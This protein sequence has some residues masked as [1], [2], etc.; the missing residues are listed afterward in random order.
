MKNKNFLIFIPT[1]NEK[2][3]VKLIYNELNSLDLKFDILFLDDD[4]PD[5]TGI[6]LDEIAKIDKKVKIIHRKICVFWFP[7]ENHAV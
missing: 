5:G 3:N 1:F 2:S 7:S 6:I 4:S